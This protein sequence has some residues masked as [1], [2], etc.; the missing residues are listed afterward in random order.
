MRCAGIGELDE[1]KAVLTT[2]TMSTTTTSSTSHPLTPRSPPPPNQPLVLRRRVLFGWRVAL[3]KIQWT[4][5]QIVLNRSKSYYISLA[6]PPTS[7]HPSI[8]QELGRNCPGRNCPG[9]G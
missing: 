8:I 2:E 9:G 3:Q 6:L 1:M 4:S 5:G 7:C